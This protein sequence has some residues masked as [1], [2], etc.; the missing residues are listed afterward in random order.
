M[1]G[2]NLMRDYAKILSPEVVKKCLAG[3]C[4]IVH[5]QAVANLTSNNT[6][7]TGM[8]RN[9]VSWALSDMKGGLNSGGSAGE[10][11]WAHGVDIP[12]DADTG[13]V[14]S[15]VEYAAAVEYGRP[16]L[17]NYPMQPYLRPAVYQT[18]GKRNR[19]I[20]TQ[21]KESIKKAIP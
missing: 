12:K 7:D 1:Q 5:G 14:G 4:V 3:I 20:Q 15:S 10:S 9:S 6:V 13:H 17:P 2:D 18:T 16:D 21:I 11:D 8:L 19:F